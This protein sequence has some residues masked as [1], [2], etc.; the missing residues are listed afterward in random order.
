VLC[1]LIDLTGESGRDLIEVVIE[2]IRDGEI[3]PAERRLVDAAAAEHRQHLA[4]LPGPASDL[5][6][7]IG[8]AGA[9]L[10]AGAATDYAFRRTREAYEDRRTRIRGGPNREA[11]VA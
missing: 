5:D 9:L 11:S 3:T 10:G 7:A 6:A 4:A 2:V 8:A 1:D